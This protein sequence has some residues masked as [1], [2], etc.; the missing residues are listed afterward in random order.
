MLQ[1][2]IGQCQP[3]LSIGQ[4]QFQVSFFRFGLVLCRFFVAITTTID[5]KSQVI[6][7]LAYLSLKC[8]PWSEGG[9]LSDEASQEASPPPRLVDL[10]HFV[11]ARLA[12]RRLKRC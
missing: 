10:L 5:F 8:A 9:C 1:V 4:C 3:Q 12:P 2:S 6:V 11:V 7:T